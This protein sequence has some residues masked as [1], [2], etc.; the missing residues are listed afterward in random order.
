MM[1]QARYAATAAELKR[2]I[3]GHLARP[4]T[5][6]DPPAGPCF[7]DGMHAPHTSVQSTM[8]VLG[9][10]VLTPAEAQPYFAFRA[11]P[12]ATCAFSCLSPWFCRGTAAEKHCFP[13][14]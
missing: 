9:Q 1:T 13:C 11:S 4:A 8:Y 3:L 12:T 2:G 10:G 5:A 7:A 6:C 14:A